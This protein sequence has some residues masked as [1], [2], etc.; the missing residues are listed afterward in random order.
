[1]DLLIAAVL[2][3]ENGTLLSIVLVETIIRDALNRQRRH[4][5]ALSKFQPPNTTA[6]SLT[7][8]IRPINFG[9][10]R[11]FAPHN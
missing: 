6:Q 3:T 4:R 9:E 5:V 8:H 7:H 2:S 10:I 11:G 1:M